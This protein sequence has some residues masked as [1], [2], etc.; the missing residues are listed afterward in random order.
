MIM[1]MMQWCTDTD[2][3]TDSDADTDTDNENENNNPLQVYFRV[4]Y[5]RGKISRCCG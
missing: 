2:T 3:D 4:E 5:F 1:A